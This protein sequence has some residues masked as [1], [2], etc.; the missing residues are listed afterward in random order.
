M[1]VATL[2]GYATLSLETGAQDFF[3]AA[4]RLY[5]RAGFEPCEPFADYVPD[6]ASRFY[7]L[8]LAAPQPPR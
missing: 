3:S 1:E 6:P 8:T 2:R 7:R 4:H 5:E